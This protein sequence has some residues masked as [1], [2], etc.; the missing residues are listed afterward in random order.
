[1]LSQTFW[2]QPEADRT[3]DLTSI[4]KPLQKQGFM[5]AHKGSN[6]GPPDYEAQ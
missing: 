3:F 5:W 6:L 2:G 4:K 1:M